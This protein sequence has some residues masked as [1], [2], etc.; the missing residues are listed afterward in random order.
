MNKTG[1][2][3]YICECGRGNPAPDSSCSQCGAK[4]RATRDDRVYVPAEAE[5]LEERRYVARYRFDSQG[6][7]SELEW[8]AALAMGR[9]TRSLLPDFIGKIDRHYAQ[10]TSDDPDRLQRFIVEWFREMGWG[11][12]EMERRSISPPYGD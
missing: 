9:L 8:P 12:A 6:A 2:W 4:M 5:E 7:D 1:R 3:E 11:P 10:F